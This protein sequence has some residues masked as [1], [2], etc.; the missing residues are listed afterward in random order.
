MAKVAGTT[1]P[2]SIG[3]AWIAHSEASVSICPAPII[4]PPD[5]APVSVHALFPAGMGPFTFAAPVLG[6]ASF[7]LFKTS[8][9]CAWGQPPNAGIHSSALV[10]G[11]GLVQL[12]VG[13]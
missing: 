4:H 11:R 5:D 1:I 13:L 8:L 12:R 7:T 10:T 2:I 3:V 6:E 9:P